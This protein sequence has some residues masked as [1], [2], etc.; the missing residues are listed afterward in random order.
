MEFELLF[1]V[2][3]T[4]MGSLEWAG[5]VLMIKVA[6]GLLVTIWKTIGDAGHKFPCDP[7]ERFSKGAITTGRR[8]QTV[9]ALMTVLE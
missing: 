2:D 5:A 1:D 4:V 8:T 3:S 6:F 7:G 9:S